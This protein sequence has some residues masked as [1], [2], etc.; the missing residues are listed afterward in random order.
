MQQ[1]PA[2]GRALSE[3]VTW[4]GFRTLDLSRLGWARILENRPIIEKN[5][6]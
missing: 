1:S 5:V 2:V 3:L 6:V 4:G